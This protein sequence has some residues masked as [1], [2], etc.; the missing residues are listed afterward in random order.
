MLQAL[1]DKSQEHVEGEDTLKL[2]K[3]NV[4]VTDR[5]SLKSH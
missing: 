2:N 1:I 5:S 4:I 3:G